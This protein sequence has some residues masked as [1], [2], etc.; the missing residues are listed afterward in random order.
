MSLF[1]EA[2]ATTCGIMLLLTRHGGVNEKPN[3]QSEIWM[4]FKL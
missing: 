4:D 1:S 3:K 2:G